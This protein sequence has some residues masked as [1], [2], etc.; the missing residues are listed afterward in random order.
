MIG[1]DGYQPLKGKRGQSSA[2][3]DYSSLRLLVRR[4]PADAR[5]I[6]RIGL[7][8]RRM[9]ARSYADTVAVI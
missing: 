9:K 2:S 1:R 3:N 7:R 6:E 8:S 4:E 5:V